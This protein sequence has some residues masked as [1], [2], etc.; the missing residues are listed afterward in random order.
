MP[1][2]IGVI[3][4]RLGSTRLP[5]KLLGPVAGRPLL[6]V[7][8]DRVR[9]AR[10]DEWWLATTDERTDDVTAAWGAW[11]GLRVFRGD[12]DDVLSRFAEIAAQRRPEWMVRLTADNPFVDARIINILIDT[13][14]VAAETT[15]YVGEGHARQFP[16]GFVPELVRGDAITALNRLELPAHDRAHVTSRIREGPGSIAAAI[17]PSW[18]RRPA[19][20]W[21]VDTSA[22]LSMADAAFRAFGGVGSSIDYRGMVTV[23]DESPEITA[24]NAH[25]RQKD[26]ADA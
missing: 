11:L 26:A 7:L 2:V 13:A 5:G 25:V 9:G 4:A 12:E 24:L 15:Q 14:D 8:V 10:V 20:R 21:T 18:P 19:W 23:L 22:D 17:D 1:R 3:Q 16:L 6:A